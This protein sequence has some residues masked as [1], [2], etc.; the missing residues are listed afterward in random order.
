M[1]NIICVN[2]YHDY[3]RTEN[4]EMLIE[5]YSISNVT[6]LIHFAFLIRFIVFIF[7]C[8]RSSGGIWYL[9]LF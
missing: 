1:W 8:R 6:T 3:D 9:D 7:A 5:E 4:K 2:S